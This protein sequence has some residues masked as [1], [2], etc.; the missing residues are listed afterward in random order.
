[1]KSKS[2]TLEARKLIPGGNS[3][4][5]KRAEMFAPEQW[6]NYFKSAKGIS[7]TD[8][9]GIVYKDFSHF[10]V[11]TNTLGYGNE[12]I[13]NAVLNG[14]KLGNMSTLNPPE[15]VYLAKKLISLHPWAGM[16]KFAR[17]GG[18]ANAIAV[19]IA[20]NYKAKN[21][22]AF[23]GYH[24]WHDWYLAANIKDPNNLDKQ[25][26]TGLSSRGVPNSLS[27]TVKPFMHGDI[28]SLE[29]ILIEG[30]VAAVKMEVMRSNYPDLNYLKEIRRL[31]SKY[32]ALLIFDE[33]TSG[34]RETFGG[35][36]LKYDVNPDIAV[37]G[38]TLGNGYAISSVIGTSE[39]MNEAQNTFISS[40]FFTERIGFIAACKVL[41]EM[42]KQKSW[43]YITYI[44]KK[45]KEGINNIL[46]K[47]NLKYE[48]A[49][50]DALASFQ[51]I[52]DEWPS[53]KTYLIQEML[54]HGYLTTNLFYPSTAHTEE[55]L[56]KFLTIY[57]SIFD[58]IVLTKEENISI[59]DLLK[60]PICHTTFQRL[61]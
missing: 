27:G 53:I 17:S 3:L 1:M 34:F 56:N 12:T 36:H 6:P 10:A 50:M 49:G 30:D 33:C 4:L 48:I 9:D 24:G 2:L 37:F 21:I 58:K 26:L 60:G 31:A 35:L 14:I 47:T 5:S 55:E 22:I 43:E 23:C 20:R 40:T 54:A 15:E 13:D 32:D 59:K 18:E 45:Y 41:E 28:E 57:E 29:K 52:D 42:E 16:A 11:G 38:K 51:I 7:V 8:L 44:G 39:V 25:L 61:N 19:R 46:S